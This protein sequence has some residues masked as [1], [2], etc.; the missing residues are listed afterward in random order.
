[1]STTLVENILA[2]I[3]LI[4][5]CAYILGSI[6]RKSPRLVIIIVLAVI[7]MGIIMNW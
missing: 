7:L 5:S 2:A 1:M 6:Y 3:I 4:L